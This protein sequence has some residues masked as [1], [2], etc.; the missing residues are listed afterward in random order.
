MCYS[1]LLQLVPLNESC[2]KYKQTGIGRKNRKKG[3][4]KE[5][6]AAPQSL[7]TEVSHRGGRVCAACSRSKCLVSV[8]V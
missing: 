8:A 4:F 7:Q 2:Q 5:I 3:K 6:Q 1:T